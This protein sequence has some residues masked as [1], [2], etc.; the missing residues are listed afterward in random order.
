MTEFDANL[1]SHGVILS[2]VN[3]LS[4][5]YQFAIHDPWRCIVVIDRNPVQV[6]ELRQ[7]FILTA[8]ANGKKYIR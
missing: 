4:F 8:V 5:S 3:F 1:S 2:H 6:V 7:A